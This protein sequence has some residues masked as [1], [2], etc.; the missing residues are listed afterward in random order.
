MTEPTFEDLVKKFDV[1]A[2]AL[3]NDKFNYLPP[4]LEIRMYREN[5][6]II[7]SCQF[8]NVSTRGQSIIGY[9]STPEESIRNYYSNIVGRRIYSHTTDGL[10]R[11]D[12]LVVD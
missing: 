12:L 3:S 9:G 10:Y 6:K 11:G 1:I 8:N 4:I 5:Q 2:Q 7:F